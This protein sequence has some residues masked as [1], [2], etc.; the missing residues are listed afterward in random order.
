LLQSR[1]FRVLPSEGSSKQIEDQSYSSLSAIATA[2][3]SSQAVDVIITHSLPSSVTDLSSFPLPH[4]D[5]TKIC[6]PP[7]DGMMKRIRPWYHFAAAGGVFQEREPL[8]WDGEPLV[9]D[10]EP[11]VWDSEP[12]VWDDEADRITRFASLGPFGKRCDST[13]VWVL[14]RAVFTVSNCPFSQHLI[15][16]CPE[17]AIL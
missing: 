12:L 6:A 16:E 9:W 1:L 5:A 14:P 7:L 4:P 15:S 2:I 10:G 11:L 8:V 17:R 3:E 13:E